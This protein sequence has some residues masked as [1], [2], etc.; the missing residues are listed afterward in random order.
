MPQDVAEQTSELHL[1]LAGLTRGF[2]PSYIFVPSL[3]QAKHAIYLD[4]CN[5]GLFRFVLFRVQYNCLL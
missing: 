3:L 4:S 2:S 5:S 1:H